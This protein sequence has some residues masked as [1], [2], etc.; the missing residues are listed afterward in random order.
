MISDMMVY[1]GRSALFVFGRGN[2]TNIL[3]SEAIFEE[4]SEKVDPVETAAAVAKAGEC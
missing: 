2:R 3:Y 1:S 4:P